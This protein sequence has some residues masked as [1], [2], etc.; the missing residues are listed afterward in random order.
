[1]SQAQKKKNKL[2]LKKQVQRDHEGIKRPRRLEAHTKKYREEKENHGKRLRS[3]DPQQSS[4]GA[5]FSRHIVKRRLGQLERKRQKKKIRNKAK[6]HKRQKNPATSHG[7]SKKSLGE[8]EQR[9]RKKRMVT[10][11]FQVGRIGFCPDRKK[12][13]KWNCQTVRPRRAYLSTSQRR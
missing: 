9:N 3:Q 10:G 8:P 7:T 13:E 1:M 2:S 11:S 4:R 5:D 6:E 12:R